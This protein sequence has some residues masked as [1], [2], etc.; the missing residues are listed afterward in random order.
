M[1][2]HEGSTS[3]FGCGRC[4]L[5]K[6]QRCGFVHLLGN[7]DTDKN[8]LQSMTPINSLISPFCIMLIATIALSLVCYMMH[9]SLEKM[10]K[11]I[12]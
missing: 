7:V 4:N 8:N 5:D 10:G 11:L 9:L 12:Y 2:T 3:A 6:V 1:D